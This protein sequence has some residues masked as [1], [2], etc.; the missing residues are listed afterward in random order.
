ML[1]RLIERLSGQV[2][3]IEEVEQRLAA[4]RVILQAYGRLAILL[5][6]QQQI[7]GTPQGGMPE[8]LAQ[9]IREALQELRSRGEHAA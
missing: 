3:E 2:D 9:A 6:T 1:R 8:P 5:R 7:E 4:M